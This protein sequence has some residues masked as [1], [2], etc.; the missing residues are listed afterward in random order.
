MASF[1]SDPGAR[2]ATLLVTAD[3][4]VIF[5]DILARPSAEVEDLAV[6]LERGVLEAARTVGA[7]PA[8][9]EVREP[10]VAVALASRMRDAGSPV[11]VRAA[12]LSGVDAAM[13]A[14]NRSMGGPAARFAPSRPDMW[15]GWGQPEEWIAEIFRASAAYHRVS[16]WRHFDNF[17]A[18]FAET[19][20]GQI[21]Y[22]SIMGSAGMTYGLA[23][24]SDP[25]DLDRQLDD[26]SAQLSGR[27]LGLTFDKARDLPRPMR[28]EIS[29]AGWEVASSDA[30]PSLIAVN[31]PAGGLRRTDARDL[32]AILS[33]V[34]AWTVAIDGDR[35]VA[36]KPWQDPETG[37]EL[38][39]LGFETYEDDERPEWA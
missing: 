9:I 3:G 35:R 8:A 22:L 23:L 21:W 19:P 36:E 39:V 10:E 20:K 29:E 31:T 1:K 38:E 14:L 27:V 33:A 2:P 18:I 26:Y 15:A 6:E 24:Y 11:V 25:D 28:K 34:A 32:V 37:V 5:T 7:L 4:F 30:Y 12:L 13:T 17:P 16:P